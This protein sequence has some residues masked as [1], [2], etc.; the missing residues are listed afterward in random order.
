M[1][2]YTDI[3]GV[4]RFC[5]GLETYVELTVTG[6]LTPDRPEQTWRLMAR[7]IPRPGRRF[8]NLTTGTEVLGIAEFL[9]NVAA[10]TVKAHITSDVGITFVVYGPDVLEP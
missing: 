5:D 9:A 1:R 4:A 8:T 6:K 7:D 3:D 10:T 2:C